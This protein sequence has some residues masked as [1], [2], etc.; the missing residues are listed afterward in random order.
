MSRFH[1][2]LHAVRRET[3]ARGDVLAS[4]VANPF[5]SL[6]RAAL[7]GLGERLGVSTV[8]MMKLRDRQIRSD[9]ITDGFRHFVADNMEVPVEVITGHFAARPEMLTGV[10]FSA[11]Q[12]PEVGPQQTFEEAVRSSGLTPEQQNRLL[13]L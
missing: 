9:T 4:A 7:R 12:K 10:H 8:F 6:D 11:E 5:A 13:S 2:R 1:N 3:G